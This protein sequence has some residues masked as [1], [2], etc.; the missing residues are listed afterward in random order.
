MV[1][2]LGTEIKT[3][4]ILCTGRSCTCHLVVAIDSCLLKYIFATVLDVS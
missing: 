3:S 4:Q 2:F 1:K